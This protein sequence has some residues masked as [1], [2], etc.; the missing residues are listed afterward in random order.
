M[1]AEERLVQVVTAVASRDEA[2]RLA[3]LAVE[4][5][6][7]ACVQFTGPVSSVYRWKGEVHTE[8][9]WVC[10]LKTPEGLERDLIALVR[11]EHPYETPEILVTAAD[12]VSGD[13]LAWAKEETTRRG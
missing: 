13:Y 5:R 11:R 9:E 2:L 6:L 7:A 10:T 1:T 8:E 12:S 4:E 3:A